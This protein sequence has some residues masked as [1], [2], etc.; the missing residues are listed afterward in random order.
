MLKAGKR[1]YDINDINTFNISRLS[2]LDIIQCDKMS[3][4]LFRR[5]V[6]SYKVDKQALQAISDLAALSCF[7]L[8]RNGSRVFQSP[9]QVLSKLTAELLC[10]VSKQYFSNTARQLSKEQSSHTE[11]STNESFDEAIN[12]ISK[13]NRYV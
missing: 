2:A 3:D 6:K 9:L 5:L 7:C 13:E 1:K 4:K 11:C 8:Y 10:E 12:Q